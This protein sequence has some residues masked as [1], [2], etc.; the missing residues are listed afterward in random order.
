MAV[1]YARARDVNRKMIAIKSAGRGMRLISFQTMM[2]I[3]QSPR[4][5]TANDRA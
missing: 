2:L 3:T 4:G 5:G 1:V